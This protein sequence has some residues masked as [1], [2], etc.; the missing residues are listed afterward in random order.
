MQ[1]S[2]LPEKDGFKFLIKF[3]GSPEKIEP[4]ATNQGVTNVPVLF[5]ARSCYVSH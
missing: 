4:T 5:L 1:I 3:H 2:P